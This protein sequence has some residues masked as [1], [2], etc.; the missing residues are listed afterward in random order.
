M[1]ITTESR[2]VPSRH[3]GGQGWHPAGGRQGPAMDFEWEHDDK[4]RM[5]DMDSKSLLVANEVRNDDHP[6]DQRLGFIVEDP[7]C[8]LYKYYQIV[9]STDWRYCGDGET[10]IRGFHTWGYPLNHPNGIFPQNTIHF[11]VPGT[12]I[13]GPIYASS[14]GISSQFPLRS[15]WSFELGHEDPAGRKFRKLYTFQWPKPKDCRVDSEALVVPKKLVWVKHRVLHIIDPQ[16]WAFLVLNHGIP[17]DHL[18]ASVFCWGPITP[19]T[20]QLHGH[21]WSQTIKRM[22]FLDFVPRFIVDMVLS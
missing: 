13:Y 19:R 12:P 15:C 2:T 4:P 5:L 1:E 10:T 6:G 9:S 17:G 22:R 8:W 14:L 18:D 20:G 21:Q 3:R 7:K 11:G 16:N